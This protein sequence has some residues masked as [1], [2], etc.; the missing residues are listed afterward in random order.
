EPFDPFPSGSA[1]YHLDFTRIFASAEAERADRAALA[2]EIDALQAMRG[3]VTVD[4]DHLLTVLRRNDDVRMKLARHAIYLY[5]RY[6]VDTRD[7]K[8]RD[9]GDGLEADAVAKSGFLRN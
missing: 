1:G 3:N 9:D 4:G 7:E 6:A 2:H 5:L 8:S